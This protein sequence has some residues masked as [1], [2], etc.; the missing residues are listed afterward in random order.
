MHAS[1]LMGVLVRVCVF[2]YVWKL[3]RIY[4]TAW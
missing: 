1:E 4:R 2:V 3:E